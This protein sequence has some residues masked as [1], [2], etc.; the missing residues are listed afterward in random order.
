[1]RIPLSIIVAYTILLLFT[2][3]SLYPILLMLL[4]SIKSKLEILTSPLGF[5][6]EF[7]F[8]SEAVKQ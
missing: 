4:N 2:F 5:P 6:M 3:I 7:S 1:M 8:T